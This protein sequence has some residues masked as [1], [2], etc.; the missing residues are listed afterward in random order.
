QAR[1]DGAQISRAEKTRGVLRPEILHAPREG[2]L[3]AGVEGLVLRQDRA[4]PG[5]LVFKIRPAAKRRGNH[6]GAVIGAVEFLIERRGHLVGNQI[7]N[8]MIFAAADDQS[9]SIV[10][11]PAFA[12]SELT[13]V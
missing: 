9:R 11:S 12:G 8:K 10:Q 2:Y 6:F 5:K 13:L 3:E 1:Q 7:C 4:Q